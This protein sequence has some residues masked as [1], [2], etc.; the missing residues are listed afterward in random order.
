MRDLQRNLSLYL[1]S[2]G[3]ESPRDPGAAGRLWDHEATDLSVAV[4]HE[5]QEGS[6]DWRSITARLAEVERV[7]VEQVVTDIMLMSTDVANLRAANDLV[8]TDTIPYEAGTAMM[9]G[10]WR[11]FRSCATT[12]RR[13][14][15]QIRGNYDKHA[16]EIAGTARMAHTKRG[17][18]IIPL[19]LPVSEPVPVDEG[20]VEAAPPE[21]VE[22]RVMRTFAE[23][24][25]KVHEVVVTPEREPRQGDALSLIFAGVSAEFATALHHVLSEEAV[26]EFGAEFQWAPA[27]GP[28]P[29]NLSKVSIPAPAAPRVDA[30]AKLLSRATPEPNVE[31]LTGPIVAV[32]RDPEQGGTI[33]ID[34][35]RKSR[36]THVSVRVTDDKRFD[37]AL[38]WMKR[39]TTVAL[40]GRI[41]RQGNVLMSDRHNGVEP[42]SARQLVSDE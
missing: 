7:T 12:S 14:R 18:F 39:R 19:L 29:E 22:R 31:I 37:D 40:E 15:A 2:H 32:A 11:M 20:L 30:V 6:L 27:A 10:A 28:Q 26:A 42:L 25:T 36:N 24:L 9:Q 35:F 4:P 34:T 17:S 16:D 8:I 21:P 41:S 23:A 38:D 13:A 3:W 33:T 1:E 5:V